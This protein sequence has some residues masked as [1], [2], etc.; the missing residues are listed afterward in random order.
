M[1][2]RKDED[3]EDEEVKNKIELKYEV[4]EDDQI[5]YLNVGGEKFTT[6]LSTLQPIKSSKLYDLITGGK[7]DKDQN[8][9]L[10]LD[11]PPEV[12]EIILNTL[13]IKKAPKLPEDELELAL[14]KKE[15]DFYGL[16]KFLEIGE[17]TGSKFKLVIPNGDYTLTGTTVKKTGGSNTWT[18]C[19]NFGDKGF[20]KGKHYW[21]FKIN[22]INSDKSGTVI[23][24]TPN[25]SGS[26]YSSDIGVGMS[27]Y[28]YNV[29]GSTISGNNGDSIG[30]LLDFSAS[31]VKFYK[32][33]TYVCTGNIS[34]GTEYFPVIH[35]YYVNDSFTL[36]FP[37]MP[38]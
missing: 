15:L 5:V 26:S 21:E 13:R 25:K 30:V 9:V 20:K 18:N 37:K 17:D 19:M 31:S 8:G 36:N 35:I 23:G 4:E 24:I 29:S 2:F 33:G 28:N 12:F 27:G 32:N 7:L 6:L 14:I 11:R 16:K 3:D 34:S 1:F 38:K 22:T 10:F